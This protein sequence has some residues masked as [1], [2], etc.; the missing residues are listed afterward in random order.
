M[1]M[2]RTTL[3]IVAGILFMAARPAAAQSFQVNID[4]NGGGSYFGPNGQSHTWGGFVTLSSPPVYHLTP[5]FAATGVNVVPVPGDIVVTE[6]AAAQIPSDLLR[7]DGNGN[8]TVFSDFE[9]TD[10]PPFDLADVGVPTPA[11]NAVFKL[12]TDQFGGPAV[13]GGENGLFGYTAGPGTPGGFPAGTAGTITY[14]F[15]SDKAVPEPS[16]LVELGVGLTIGLLFLRRRR[17]AAV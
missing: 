17:V 3:L 5:A 2:H 6:T 14:N 16:T 12:E 7:F 13:E 10:K 1:L 4:E 9:S 8:L 15:I 11:T